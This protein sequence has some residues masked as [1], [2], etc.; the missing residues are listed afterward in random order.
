MGQISIK[1][2][3]LFSRGSKK[4][5]S[6]LGIRCYT[7]M[8]SEVGNVAIVTGASSGIGYTACEYLLESG[9]ENLIMSS[10]NIKKGETALNQLRVRFPK[11]TL[12]FIKCDVS[13]SA[14]VKSKWPIFIFPFNY[15][16]V[17]CRHV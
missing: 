17:L 1:K 8:R 4:I 2:M 15:F 9:V 12:C 5:L 10:S 13:K 3:S 16:L 14:E 6:K 11:A 7:P